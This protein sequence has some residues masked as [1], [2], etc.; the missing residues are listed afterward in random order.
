MD[1]YQRLVRDLAAAAN[2]QAEELAGAERAYADGVAAAAAELRRATSAATV[3][4]R[5]AARAASA[6]VDVD[7]EAA[8]LWGQLH[9]GRRGRSVPEPTPVEP[10]GMPQDALVALARAT[11]DIDAGRVGAPRAPMPVLATPV[12]P[13]LGAA[14]AAV[15]G[16]VAGGFVTLADLGMPGSPVVR[17]F[18]WAL[19]LTA[20][21][22]GVPVAAVWVARRFTSRLDPGAAG[23]TALGGLVGLFALVLLT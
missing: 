2:R 16:L 20:P 1:D 14:V 21:F 18:G 11:R 6:V 15:A 23:L 4:E 10:G 8:R 3:A 17:G 22:S 5:R 13:F 9:R 19:F 12:L 7:R